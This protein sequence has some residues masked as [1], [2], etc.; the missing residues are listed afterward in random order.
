MFFVSLSYYLK[1]WISACNL[2]FLLYQPLWLT[3][4]NY[5]YCR[6]YFNG[7][8][9]FVSFC[10]VLSCFVPFL[11]YKSTRLQDYKWGEV[12]CFKTTSPSKTS[13]VDS[14]SLKKLPTQILSSTDEKLLFFTDKIARNEIL[15]RKFGQNLTFAL[16]CVYVCY[17]LSYTLGVI[18]HFFELL[19]VPLPKIIRDE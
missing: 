1:R 3:L 15:L 19:F 18:W 14:L 10:P 2:I 11:D 7:L 9:R 13:L 4:Q 5:N 17:R 8:S 6:T 12:G 16:H